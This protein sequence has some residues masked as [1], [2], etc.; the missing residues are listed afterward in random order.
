VSGYGCEEWCEASVNHEG[1][2]GPAT[3]AAAGLKIEELIAERD[4]A[5]ADLRVAIEER[6]RLRSDLAIYM[7]AGN[8]ACLA[9]EAERDRFRAER[10]AMEGDLTNWVAETQKARLERNRLRA[11][12]A[13]TPENR[14]LVFDTWENG[15]AED[16]D[17]AA[18][19]VLAALRAR[20]D[21]T[22][23]LPCGHPDRVV[24]SAAMCDGARKETP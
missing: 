21:E 13:D 18:G 7:N 2:C 3:A 11:V 4:Q 10:D 17:G 20:A 9:L 16:M 24:C 15:A 1:P 8:E 6:E 23:R 14:A 12:L 5:R 22:P 19:E